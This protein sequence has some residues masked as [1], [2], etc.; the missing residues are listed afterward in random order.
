MSVLTVILASALLGVLAAILL[1]NSFFLADKLRD[2]LY[3]ARWVIGGEGRGFVSELIPYLSNRVTSG[4]QG[5]T[6]EEYINIANRFNMP[7]TLADHPAARVILSSKAMQNKGI[8]H[9]F[10]RF[11]YRWPSLMLVQVAIS[12]AILM[13]LAGF[14][15]TPAIYVSGVALL[16][17]G[18][19]TVLLL[20]SLVVEIY[21][22]FVSRL[23]MGYVAD[24]FIMSLTTEGTDKETELPS[25]TKRDIICRLMFLVAVL[26]SVAI[27]CATTFYSGLQV[28]GVSFLGC[29]EPCFSG[30][31]QSWVTP[32]MCLYF[33]ICNL[34]TV[35]ANIFPQEPLAYIAVMFQVSVDVSILVF[36][37]SVLT[38]SL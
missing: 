37:M 6:I 10:T 15:D 27:L 11:Y 7:M 3:D 28:A 31:G 36:L 16:T 33:S 17:Y 4:Y 20:S 9:L 38:L 25:L 35:S 18:F 29:T 12:L 32:F 13:V 24:F 26:L 2:I 21:Y 5:L 34:G 14:K 30:M 1:V 8:R 22:A 23:Y 19:A